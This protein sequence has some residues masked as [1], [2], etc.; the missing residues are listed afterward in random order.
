M[1]WV[2]VPSEKK[3]KPAGLHTPQLEL[4]AGVSLLD[5]GRRKPALFEDT[6]T[7]EIQLWSGRTRRTQRP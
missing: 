5:E 7:P 6:K 1:A 4:L 2:S 3:S